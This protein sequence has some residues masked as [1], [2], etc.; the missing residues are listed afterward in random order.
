MWCTHSVSIDDC[1]CG[2][3]PP[4]PPPWQ[5]PNCPLALSPRPGPIAG[6]STGD[7]DKRLPGVAISLLVYDGL[8]IATAVVGVR[9]A[10]GL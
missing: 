3:L 2:L 9:A 10:L 6:Y 8:I 4:P 1:C 7:P 5:R